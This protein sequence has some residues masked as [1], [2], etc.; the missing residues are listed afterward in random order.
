MQ[1]AKTVIRTADVLRPERLGHWTVALGQVCS[2][3]QT[4]GFGSDSLDGQIELARLGPIKL[5]DIA[6]SRH[7][8][9]QP[10][11]GPDQGAA[12]KAVYQLHGRSIYRQGGVELTVDPGDCVIYDVSQPHIVLNPDRNRHL[13]V[14]MPK[15]VALANDI[16]FDRTPLLA[17]RSKSGLVRLASRIIDATINERR[18]ISPGD[19]NVITDMVLRM[20]RQSQHGEIRPAPGSAARPGMNN[21]IR[22]VVQQHLRNP[23]F[24]LDRLAQIL[25]CSKRLLHLSFA[26]QDMTISEYLWASRLDKCRQ[27]LSVR[28]SRSPSITD[29]ALSWG[30]N[31]TSHFSRSFKARFGVSP[32]TF[33]KT[34]DV[35]LDY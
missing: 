7:R 25:R 32:S 22:R 17:P 31:S 26:D 19:E 5:C 23:E 10:H 28:S 9:V 2:G 13:V 16:R 20:V 3:L 15:D 35:A 6:A 1:A 34:S 18:E 29:I 14:A 24:S 4:D 8:I 30:F 11:P 33:A 21:E 12:I 27:E